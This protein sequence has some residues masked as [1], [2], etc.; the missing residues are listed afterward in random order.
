MAQEPTA[1]WGQLPTHRVK[2]TGTQGN[3]FFFFLACAKLEFVLV[4]QLLYK[5][6]SYSCK[7]G[8]ADSWVLETMQLFQGKL[9]L[10]GN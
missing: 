5:E 8:T 1:E 10:F 9:S 4:Q 2:S 3:F 6:L 7:G